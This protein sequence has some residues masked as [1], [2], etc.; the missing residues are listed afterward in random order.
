MSDALCRDNDVL[1]L[2]SGVLESDRVW[3]SR[4]T[5]VELELVRD[6]CDCRRGRHC[7]DSSDVV[8]WLSA[9]MQRLG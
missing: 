2:R 6:F 4:R 3:T 1:G 8:L 7:A 5:V 9:L